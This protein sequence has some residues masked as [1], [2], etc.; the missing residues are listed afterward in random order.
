M[1]AVQEVGGESHAAAP[2]SLAQPEEVVTHMDHAAAP[3][4]LTMAQPVP[5]Q[6]MMVVVAAAVSMARQAA[7]EE[8]AT[9]KPL[10][11]EPTEAGATMEQQEP[12]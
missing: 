6:A 10:P 9:R 7:S 12:A 2:Q 8:T 1:E 4:S 3:Q 11:A 5:E